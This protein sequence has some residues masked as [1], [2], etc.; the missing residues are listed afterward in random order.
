[1]AAVGIMVGTITTPAKAAKPISA[2]A[3][4]SP[5]SNETNRQ[6]RAKIALP[7]LDKSFLTVGVAEIDEA[8]STAA[9]SPDTV[10][11]TINVHSANMR[12]AVDAISIALTEI[13]FEREV[14]PR[15]LFREQCKFG[16]QIHRLGSIH[17]SADDTLSSILARAFKDVARAEE[18]CAARPAA[19]VVELLA[20]DSDEA[21]ERWMLQLHI[22]ATERA[23]SSEELRAEIGIVLRQVQ[24]SAVFLPPL[25]API[26]ATAPRVRVFAQ[27]SAPARTPLPEG[28]TE[29]AEDAEDDD[30]TDDEVVLPARLSPRR[31][32][33]ELARRK[34]A[35]AAAA[36]TD[37][38]RPPAFS[39]RELLSL[40]APLPELVKPSGSWSS[41]LGV[42]VAI[43]GVV[44]VGGLLASRLARRV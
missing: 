44:A 15:E 38:P 29:D 19:L 42:A 9:A 3:S 5:L 16:L 23:S 11:T 8:V 18:L 31:A 21:V 20:R 33:A 6:N 40:A 37:G 34:A 13:L 7:A 25:D 17:A 39:S 1:M 4:R 2:K 35:A 41:W 43:G 10:T 14:Y 26:E 24:R 28:D 36:P 32:A 30:D 12:F 27:A 22:D